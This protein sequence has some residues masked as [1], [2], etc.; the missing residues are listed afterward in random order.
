MWGEAASG[1]LEAAPRVTS[2]KVSSSV[3]RMEATTGQLMRYGW[4]ARL[5]GDTE[6]TSG[7]LPSKA[8]T[9]DQESAFFFRLLL[10][11]HLLNEKKKQEA[12]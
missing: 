5:A 9:S 7:A 1:V 3:L 6:A 11:K 12:H 4:L 2:E 10:R 8:T